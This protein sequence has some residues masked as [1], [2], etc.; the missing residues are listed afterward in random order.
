MELY[1]SIVCYMNSLLDYAKLYYIIVYMK[2]GTA[3]LH[4]AAVRGHAEAARQLC[5]A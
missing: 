3:S 4:F 2:D 1:Y 5:Q